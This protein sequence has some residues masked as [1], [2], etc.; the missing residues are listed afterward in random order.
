MA[1]SCSSSAFRARWSETA[2]QLPQRYGIARDARVPFFISEY[3]GT[4]WDIPKGGW[5]YGRMPES[6]EAF[7]ERFEG[8]ARVLMDNRSFFGLC[9]TQLTDVEQE[10][11]GIYTFD[12]EQKFDTD[13][14][15][16]I[17]GAPAAIEAR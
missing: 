12:R 13:K 5:G 15:R 17:F 3:G 7:Y 8:L 10:V 4:G 9:Y 6:K 1:S 14:L 16:A 11:N 2:L